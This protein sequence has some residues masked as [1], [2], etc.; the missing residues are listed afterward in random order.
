MAE[1]ERFVAFCERAL[2]LDNGRPFVPEEFQRWM[3]EPFFA[4]ASESILSTPKGTGKHDRIYPGE[5]AD[6]LRR[7]HAPGN[8]HRDAKQDRHAGTAA[9]IHRGYGDT[10][11]GHAVARH[12]EN[13]R[14]HGTCCHRRARWGRDG[15][16]LRAR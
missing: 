5:R 11:V 14:S 3:L 8:D 10:T 6:E 15:R 1:L 16:P 9:H 7:D 4:G 13:R 12:A 2:T